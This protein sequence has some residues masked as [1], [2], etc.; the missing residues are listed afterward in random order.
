VPELCP[1]GSALP[2]DAC[3]GR[4]HSGAASAPT[5]LALMRSRYSAFA[6]DD[7]AYLLRT[8]H[9]ST[10]PQRLVLDPDQRWSRLVV[11][12]TTGGGLLDREGT[13]EFRA[14][15]SR[16]GRSEALHERSRFVREAGAWLYVSAL[17]S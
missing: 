4:L 11:L 17:P 15:C 9:L 7:L 14:E 2:Y 8:W 1:C 16:G 6:V 5:A 10:R 12:A 13:V 3:C